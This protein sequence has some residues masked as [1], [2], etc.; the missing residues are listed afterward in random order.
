MERF[1]PTKDYTKY[2]SKK[3]VKYK[4]RLYNDTILC[5][6]VETTSAYLDTKN[7]KIIGFD[8]TKPPEYYKPFTKINLLYEWTFAIEDECVIYGRTLDELKSLL[9]QFRSNLINYIIW[10]HNASYEFMYLLNI[11]DISDVF[12]RKAHKIMY[13]RCENLEFRCS[14]M[15]TRLSLASWGKQEKIPKLYGWLDYDVIRTPRTPLSKRQLRYCEHDVL[16]MVKGLKRYRTRYGNL[17]SIPLTQTGEVRRDVKGLFKDDK[18]HYEL[19]TRLLPPDADFYNFLLQVFMGGYV[20]ASYLYSGKLQENVWSN[21]LTSA[22]PAEMALSKFP[23]TPWQEIKPTLNNYR[24]YN[25]DDHSLLLEVELYGIKAKGFNTYI[26]YSK[27][28]GIRKYSVDNGRIIRAE[29]VKLSITNLDLDIIETMYDI[30]EIRINRLY[31]ARNGYLNKKLVMYVLERFKGKNTLSGVAGMEDL[32]LADKQKLNSI[33]GLM[34]QK[35]IEL[36]IQFDV[37][38]EKVWKAVK[39]TNDEINTHLQELRDKPY[40]NFLSYSQGIFITAKVRKI[41]C[42]MIAK[43]DDGTVYADTD[44]IKYIG[45]YLYLFEEYNKKNIA[46]IQYVSKKRGIPIEYFMPKD[47]NGKVHILG[48][49]EPDKGT[50]YKEFKTLGAK[51]YAYED[52]NNE[53]HITVSGVNKECGV[54]ALNRVDD[55]KNEFIFD[56]EYAKKGMLTYL[57]DMPTITW[58]KG[59]PDEYISTQRYGVHMQAARYKLSLSQMYVDLLKSMLRRNI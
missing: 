12:A 2:L 7:K 9:N 27:H 46:R 14:Y 36:M 29:Y 37:S 26:P 30:S 24:K 13:A 43:M 57:Y 48:N 25:N 15:L 31:M 18:R 50:P 47:I 38:T 55:F 39:P 34:V 54:K 49:F 58:Q 42:T 35:L 21:D 8:K 6:D 51:R 40:K 10:S 45:D 33:F 52:C 5:L 17:A 19:M 41:I 23:V 4:K 16:I 44:A 59:E 3:V 1:T 32:Y 22:Y 28:Q 53:K 20:H 56:Y 11:L